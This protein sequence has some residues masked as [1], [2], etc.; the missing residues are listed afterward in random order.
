M[1]A[2]L[3]VLR[4]EDP[5]SKERGNAAEMAAKAIFESRG[6]TPRLFRNTLFFLA[7]DQ[8][9]LIDLDE[10]VRRFLAWESILAEKEALN[11]DP[12]QVKQA[13]TQ[14]K[15]ANGTVTARVP[16]AYQW[17]L[18]PVQSSPQAPLEWQAFRLSG[19]DALAV[20]ASKKLRNDELLVTAL[21][22]TRLRMEL[23]RVP[24]WRGDSVPIK[25]LAE[26]FARYLYLPRLTGT[27]V[28]VGAI[29]DGLGLLTWQQE[30]FAYADSF[31][32]T[33]NRWRGLRGGQLVALS[34]ENLSG[35][36]VRPEV[37]VRQLEAEA[38]PPPG[39]MP[40]GSGPTTPGPGPTPPGKDPT[41]PKPAPGPKRFHGTV[42]LDS[43]RVGRDAGKIAEEVI[44]HLVG[45]QGSTVKVTLEIEA[46]IPGGAPDYVVRTVTENSRTL[47]FT[48]QG[49]E[50][51]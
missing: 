44:A 32:D 27:G 4:I 19:S 33:A 50:S 31:D 48:S 6:N 18:V 21:A 42:A 10:A 17:L 36:L 5:Y 45:L 9:R 38:P 7:V 28:L 29:R 25:Q 39:P 40:P 1:D 49:F 26:D 46:G 23:D 41:P 12:H 24:L 30:S 37:A 14:Q 11:L 2:R 3:V 34:E 22:G 51:E 8:T 35:V 20:R 16:E 13:E 43:T 47:K 15:S